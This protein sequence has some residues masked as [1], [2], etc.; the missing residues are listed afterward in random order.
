MTDP[1]RAANEIR[2]HLLDHPVLRRLGIEVLRTAGVGD[3]LVVRARHRDRVLTL[4]RLGS[5]ASQSAGEVATE[6][7]HELTSEAL[8]NGRAT[9]P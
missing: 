3:T 8:A 2:D 6:L 7:V 4:E 9:T 1:Q 5:W